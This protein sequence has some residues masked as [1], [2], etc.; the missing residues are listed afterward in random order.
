M[1]IEPLKAH[2]SEAVL[3]AT[4]KI[5]E[6]GILKLPKASMRTDAGT[7]FQG[8]YHKF[9]HDHDIMHKISLPDR[10]KQTGNVERLNKELSRI[11]MGHL[12]T[13]DQ[14]NGNV[15]TNW[16]DL[17]PRIREELNKVRKKKL[18]EGKTMDYPSFDPSKTVT[19][20]ITKNK[21]KIKVIQTEFV[22]AQYKIGDRVH[23]IL[24]RPEN[25]RGEKQIGGF[26]M[27]DHRWSTEKKRI[28][29]VLLYPGLQVQYRYILEGITQAS[30]T[31]YEL[32]K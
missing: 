3:N 29:R 22:E 30:F 28:E 14:K 2:S 18:P 19:K 4:K 20:T 8:V 1:D 17:V 26:R 32:K 24:D 12:D 5:F 13:L 27:G 10:H 16:L 6:R 15:N 9:L 23:H 7:E 21:K 11:I 31:R 25:A